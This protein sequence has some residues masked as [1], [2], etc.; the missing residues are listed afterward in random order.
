M[1]KLQA[2]QE[3]FEKRIIHLFLLK[4]Y[5]DVARI[6]RSNSVKN[7]KKF[8]NIADRDDLQSVDLIILHDEMIIADSTIVLA[9]RASA[10]DR[11][12][13]CGVREKQ[14]R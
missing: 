10:L 5:E 12:R 6:D 1:H 13:H 11:A 9:T 2:L 3:H 7:S 8:V 4:A 14:M